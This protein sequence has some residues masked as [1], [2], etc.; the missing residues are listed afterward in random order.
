MKEALYYEQLDG[1][2]IKCT[3][4]PRGCVI[5]DSKT[6]SCDIRKNVNG[7]LYSLVYEK[8][9]AIHID[10]I[11][12]KPLYHFYPGS[13][14]LS[15]GTYG[16]N[17][18]CKFCQNYDLSQEF[19]VSHFE[20][21]DNI[22]PEEIIKTC[23]EKN[24]KFVAFTYNEPT[25][26]FEYMLDIAK[27]C[28][29]NN[30]KTVSVSNGQINEK[31]LRELIEYM[32]AFNIDLKAFN[33]DFYK[34]ICNGDLETTKN[35]LKIIVEEKK[36]LEVTFLL[37]EGFNDD[38]KEFRQMCEFVKGLGDDVVFHISRAFPRYKLKFETTPIQLIKKFEE[39]A[40]EY[41]KYVYVGNVY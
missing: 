30:I 24:L 37:I 31:P 27:L 36:H 35:T 20:L 2:I 33:E 5:A 3:L 21:I 23:K 16:C 15:I 13:S 4:C 40:K 14:I 6:G 38:E 9:V 12:K 18:D 8:P 25:V 34:K 29:A 39:I 32:D 11:E 17:L 41:I 7:K 19:E 1:G 28:K 10:P 22:E 26:F